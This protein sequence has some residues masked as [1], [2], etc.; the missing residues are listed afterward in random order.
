M[1]IHLI[2]FPLFL[3][4]IIG[5][6]AFFSY[7]LSKAMLLDHGLTGDFGLK[8]I[9]GLFFLGMIGVIFNFFIPL[10]ST[11]YLCT[12]GF[13]IVSGGILLIKEQ[14]HVTRV[15][16]FGFVFIS[17]ILA[18]LAG[19][20]RPGFDGGLYHLPLQLWLRSESIVIGLANFHDRFGFSSL[21]EYIS[22]S[23]WIKEQFTLLSYLQVSFVVYFLLFLIKQARLSSGTH[24][25]LLFG[26][27]VNLAVFYGYIYLAYTYTDL[28][29]GFIFA[30]TFIYGHWLLY[31]DQ[32]V[33]R[34]EWT[35]FVILLL[36]AIFY[37]VSSALLLL[38]FV[39]V[40]FYRVFLKN[41]SVR[42]CLFGL[43]IPAG[44]LLIWLLRNVLTTGCLL[45]PESASCL[46]VPWSA[47]NNATQ[48]ANWVTAWAR[49]PRSGLSPLQNNSWFLN[50]WLPNYQTFLIKFI[51]VG[52]FVGILYGS[53]ALRSRFAIM[54][55]LDI[56]IVAATGF[57][58]IAF[59]FWF[60]KAPTPRFG[61]GVFIIFFPVL[62]LF[63]HGKTLER[64]DNSRKLLQAI[65]VIGVVIFICRIGAPW[66]KISFDNILTINVLTVPEPKVIEDSVYGVRPIKGYYQCWLIP[67]CTPYDRPPKLSWRGKSAF[68]SNY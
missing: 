20:M 14:N 13:C 58:L 64:P 21:Y 4:V 17:L 22:A 51:S 15:D 37:K 66:E 62:F 19:S 30:T 53:I 41:D 60:W 26:I 63:L 9:L 38:W 59:V 50:W 16:V 47:K 24:L 43:A 56:R 35:V 27:T 31:R 2:F 39:F 29:A 55:I 49:H 48:S 8:G 5:L 67:E 61:I 12:I 6:G 23:L 11:V 28:P 46:D 34:G 1:L 68:Y 54:K 36:S 42:E 52:L 18:P 45:Y 33:L 3:L 32:A 40:L 10:T 25:A 44:F 65:V 57:V 7:I